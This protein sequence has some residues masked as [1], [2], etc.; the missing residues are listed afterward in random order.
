MADLRTLDRRLY[1]Y[2][3]WLYEVGKYYDAR[4]QVTSAYRSW[5][6]QKRLYD[7][8]VSGTSTIMA[9]VPGRSQH[10]YRVAFDLARVGID[11]L[12]D[13]LLPALG[14]LWQSMG[15]LYGGPR[16]PVHFGVRV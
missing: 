7:K 1:P 10:Q 8:W 15:G 5:A 11:P 14:R 13:E 12:S 2:A 9:A 6:S 4:L 16:D 3:K